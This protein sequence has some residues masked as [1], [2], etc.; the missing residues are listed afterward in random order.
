MPSQKFGVE[1]PHSANALAAVS[2][3]VPR[4]TA[5]TMPAGMP[6]EQR[7]RRSPSPR[8]RSSP[9][10][11]AAPARAPAAACAPIRRGR[12]AARRRSSRRSAPAAARRG[13]A[14]RA[15]R[16][17][18]VGSCSSPARIFAGSPGSSCCRP[19]ISID[20]KISVGTI[21]AEALDE[22]ARTSQR[23]VD[24]QSTVRARVRHLQARAPAAA[25]RGCCARRSAW[26][27][28]PTASCGGTDR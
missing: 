28:R 1:R 19:K 3:A 26:R 20:T 14:S 2:H 9:A 25:R 18:T 17:S 12:R 22:V 16:R 24:A 11:S 10:A 8:A 4:P 21:V 27:C 13:A 7:D 6:I 15:G 5:A 23:D